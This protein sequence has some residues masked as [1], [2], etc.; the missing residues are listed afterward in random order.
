[1]FRARNPAC[2]AFQ[3]R[4]LL[5]RSATRGADGCTDLVIFRRRGTTSPASA[6]RQPEMHDL[7]L[8][9]LLD[10][11]VEAV[12]RDITY[13]NENAA[14]Q[15]REAALSRI[16]NN[17]DSTRYLSSAA[18]ALHLAE[19]VPPLRRSSPSPRSSNA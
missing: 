1:M 2:G 13:P 6:D 18:C 4:A 17:A 16:T 12:G 3:T 8:S 19:A 11:V 7:A 15:P 5:S 14:T 10:L 9:G